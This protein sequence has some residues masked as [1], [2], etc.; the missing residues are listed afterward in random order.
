[1][2]K[3]ESVIKWKIEDKQS[4]GEI[5]KELKQAHVLINLDFSKEFMVFSFASEYTIV[6][7][8]QQKNQQAMEQSIAFFSRVLKDS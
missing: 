6:G 7:V 5:K 8:F 3:K 1:M 4:F 2:L